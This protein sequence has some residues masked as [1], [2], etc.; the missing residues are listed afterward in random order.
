MRKRIRKEERRVVRREDLVG[1]STLEREMDGKE[2]KSNGWKGFLYRNKMIIET[3]REVKHFY[4][5][6]AA[7]HRYSCDRIETNQNLFV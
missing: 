7:T 1:V 3:Y 2:R 4:S 6:C 5:G